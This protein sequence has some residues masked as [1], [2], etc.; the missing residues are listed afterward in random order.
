MASSVQK[1][2]NLVDSPWVPVYMKD[3]TCTELSLHDLFAQMGD[4]ESITTEN[5]LIDLTTMRFLIA[6]IGRAMTR[7]IAHTVP[8]FKPGS[9]CVEV[10][11]HMF[12]SRDDVCATTIAYLDAYHDR[13]DLFGDAPFMQVK[14]LGVPDK[15][16]DDLT[17]LTK[18]IGGSDNKADLHTECDV[19]VSGHIAYPEAAR[20][21]IGLQGADVTGIHSLAT[22]EIRDK[23][24]KGLRIE[25]G[26]FYGTGQTRGTVAAG[27][28]TTIRAQNL[29]LELC[30]NFVFAEVSDT[31]E[32]GRHV[33]DFANDIPIWEREPLGWKYEPIG[34][35]GTL[36]LFTYQ[37]RRVRLFSKEDGYVTGSFVT[38]Q[39]G[40]DMD[41]Y[42]RYETM[43]P[44]RLNDDLTWSTPSF[45]KSDLY[46][47]DNIVD[48]FR[49]PT[50]DDGKSIAR[51]ISWQ[52]LVKE[53]IG[54]VGNPTRRGAATPVDVPIGI[55]CSGAAYNRATTLIR[56]ISDDLV[57]SPLFWQLDNNARAGI[58]RLYELILDISQSVFGNI[59]ER[60]L[61]LLHGHTIDKNYRTNNMRL[62]EREGYLM[63]LDYFRER[64]L[65]ADNETDVL[66]ERTM[67]DIRRI[68]MRYIDS[69]LQSTSTADIIGRKCE[70]KPHKKEWVSTATIESHAKAVLTIIMGKVMTRKEEQDA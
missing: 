31:G 18:F 40:L 62:I 50:K 32:L 56:I 34:L 46:I 69:R 36:D 37:S 66:D 49:D 59:I 43:S 26:K 21:L 70:V 38:Y 30:H 58:V 51:V 35:R 1:S 19:S 45:T 9:D 39:D 17:A 61:F 20:L 29:W 47:M 52:G 8:W 16:Q 54:V 7:D 42:H 23:S 14:D 65:D 55:A 53:A 2:F 44:F 13:F 15:K 11:R 57:L 4:I 22:N 68:S 67:A 63:L 33:R 5:R 28:T 6:I 48:S 27:C 24:W 10:I 25:S 41:L 64:V 12:A 3:G 60:E